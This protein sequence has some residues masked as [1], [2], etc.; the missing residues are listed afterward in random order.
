MTQQTS[1]VLV[2]D[3]DPTIRESV[4]DILELSGYQTV[5]ATNGEEG[6]DVV[7]RLTPDLIISD[8]MMPDMSG[9]LFYEMVRSQPNLLSVPFIFLSAKG[10]QTDIRRG[11]RLGADFYLTK[12]F[13]PE[14]LLIAVESRLRRVREIK[15]RIESDVEDMKRYI[16][17]VVG[18]ELR[19]PLTLIYGSINLLEEATGSGDEEMVGRLLKHLEKG[20][21]RLSDLVKDLM[22]IAYA[23]S[24]GLENELNVNSQ[25]VTLRYVVDEVLLSLAPKAEERKV[26]ILVEAAGG[27]CVDGIPAY[28][29]EVFHKLIDNAI[30]FSH[31]QGGRVW[32]RLGSADGFAVVEVQDEGIGIAAEYQ[33]HLFERFRQFDRKQMEQQGVGIG[34]AIADR[35]V[36]LHRGWIE[37]EST[38]GVGS[39]FAV[40]LPLCQPA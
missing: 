13:E 37:V 28:I 26:A 3:D 17:N 9:Y 2:V 20:T 27:P 10:E 33:Q 15:E 12:P 24:G 5:T 8:I 1:V 29:Q 34:L 30:K 40:R 7:G 32:I 31:S 38:P 35:L 6:V 39:T 14:D 36:R 23:D 4:V 19:T 11:Y 22:L 21:N 25:P 16:L 18:H